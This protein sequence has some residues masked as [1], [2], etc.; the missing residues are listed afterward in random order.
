MAKM[1]L[2]PAVPAAS[3]SLSWDFLGIS[4]SGSKYILEFRENLCSVLHH[5]LPGG[6]LV[7]SSTALEKRT[8]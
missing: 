8:R 4:M 1:L 2:I 3:Q 6:F 5:P 7:A